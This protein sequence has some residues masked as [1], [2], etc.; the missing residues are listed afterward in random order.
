MDLSVKSY[1]YLYP[2]PFFTDQLKDVAR[3]RNGLHIRL[4]KKKSNPLNDKRTKSR[5]SRF[6]TGACGRLQCLR[7]VCHS[8]SALVRSPYSRVTTIIR[9]DHEEHNY[10]PTDIGY[11][12]YDIA[13]K[14]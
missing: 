13:C 3:L 6:D 7:A 12:S 5:V 2:L 10:R 1:T 11:S 8:V 4:P 14:L 9:T